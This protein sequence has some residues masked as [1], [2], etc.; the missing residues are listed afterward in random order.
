M[1]TT[2]NAGWFVRLLD[3]APRLDAHWAFWQAFLLY[4]GGTLV[5]LVGPWWFGLLV[6]LGGVFQT[7]VG[8][9]NARRGNWV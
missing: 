4:V 2:S 7:I 6:L 9:A 5:L 8:I 1:A 3:R